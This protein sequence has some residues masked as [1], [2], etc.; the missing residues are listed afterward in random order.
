M[1]FAIG[2]QGIEMMAYIKETNLLGFCI[3]ALIC[4]DNGQIQVSHWNEEY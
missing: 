3:H 2:L 4:V 1:C